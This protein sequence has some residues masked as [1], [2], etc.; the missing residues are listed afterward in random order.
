MHN[1]RRD[2]RLFSH[3]E[4]AERIAQDAFD[5]IHELVVAAFHT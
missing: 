5:Q 3:R 1:G 2:L 4:E